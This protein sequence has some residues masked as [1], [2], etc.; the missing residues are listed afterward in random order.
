MEDEREYFLILR[1]VRPSFRDRF[2]MP[3]GRD[4]VKQ[5]NF[6]SEVIGKPF[7]PLG[8]DYTAE[9]IL[10]VSEKNLPGELL[11]DKKV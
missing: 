8:F 5:K 11:M 9:G 4:F 3:V 7:V 2:A 10:Y 6:V 1:V